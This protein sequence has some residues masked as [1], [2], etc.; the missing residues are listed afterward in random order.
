MNHTTSF[1]LRHRVSCFTLILAAWIGAVPV[2]LPAQLIIAPAFVDFGSRTCTTGIIT[3][4]IS[5]QNNDIF[6]LTLSGAAI[7]PTNAD[8]FIVSPANLTPSTPI[9]VNPGTIEAIVVAYNP[10]RVGRI[11]ATLV[12]A[13]NAL[14]AQ[15]GITSIPLVAQRDSSG[16]VLSTNNLAFTGV[17]I[18]TSVSRNITVTNTGSIPFRLITPLFSGAFVLDSLS[19]NPI[20]PNQSAQLTVRF[21]GA[22]AGITTATA[23]VLN[24]DCGRTT[25]LTISAAVQSP[26]TITAF[27]PNIGT[28]GT[29]VVISGTNLLNATAVFFGGVPAQSFRVDSPTQITAIVG[30]GATGLVS[31]SV[32]GSVGSSPQVFVFL[33]A[34]SVL[35][36]TPLTGGTGT[37]VTIIGTNFELVTGVR[38]GDTPAQFFQ[39][40]N[41]TQITA[42]VGAGASGF[43]RVSTS[44]STATS[45]QRFTFIQ[46]PTILFITP[47]TGASGTRVTIIG[48]NLENAR[49]VSFGGVPAESVVQVSPTQIT[50]VVGT[51]GATGNVNVSTP[52]GF[53]SSQQQFVFSAPPTITFV[54]PLVGG[55]G[56][57]VNIIGTNFS[58]VTSVRFGGV[59]AQTFTVSSPF[60]ILATVGTG[61]SGAITVLTENGSTSATQAFTYGAPPVIGAFTPTSGG[62]GTVVNIFGSLFSGASVVT[63]G[64]FP[65][66][67]FEVLSPSQIRAVVGQGAS[68]TIA[69]VTEV[70]VGFSQQ[71]FGF[72]PT[73][74]AENND[75]SGLLQALPNPATET[76]TLRY[77]LRTASTARLEVFSMVGER[78][79]T[80]QDS[81]QSAGTHTAVW[82]VGQI[83][84][85]VYT[86]RLQAGTAGQ[87]VVLL[88]VVH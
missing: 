33:P 41:P 32:G 50:A 20:P 7:S 42:V 12:V 36:V 21:F 83:P 40:D 48:T 71:Q 62:P 79:C 81:L 11:T 30:Q 15:G 58:N 27:A 54:S 47:Q 86:C 46:P 72:V 14:N 29:P 49:S 61:A 67:S 18:N 53:S 19:P 84:Q 77:R 34:P 9:F 3:Q 25:S 6:T 74:V 88:R 38:F 65:A 69:V 45:V 82:D 26:P 13:S 56:T 8:F 66:R 59:P 35:F 60:Q 4:T 55:P 2:I 78:V 73:A 51:G 76:V 68:G 87:R 52:G 23:I 1:S 28:V 10:A 44:V 80:L 31:V 17:P 63:F 64:G 57:V 5:I 43:V 70:G 37:T 24:N 39:V 22:P 85:G 75:E 16:I